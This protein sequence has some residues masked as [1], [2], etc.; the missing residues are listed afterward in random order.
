MP[1]SEWCWQPWPRLGCWLGEHALAV[2]LCLFGL[3]CLWWKRRGLFD[4]FAVAGFRIV[5]SRSWRRCVQRAFWLLER[6]VLDRPP[7]PT[8]QTPSAW[9]RTAL[10]VPP[11]EGEEIR[12]LI[13][14]AEWCAY[15]QSCRPLGTQP[16]CRKSAAEF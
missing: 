2:G 13:G 7:A 5:P 10:R 4:A 11:N 3:V 6:R 8:S 16:K 1:W 15:A 9:L 12:Q 14:I